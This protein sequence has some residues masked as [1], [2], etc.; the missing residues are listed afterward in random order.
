M[1]TPA[2]PALTN[3]LWKPTFAIKM[4]SINGNGFLLNGYGFSLNGYG[5]SLNG[6]GF[7]LHGSFGQN[8]KSCFQPKNRKMF[9]KTLEFFSKLHVQGSIIGQPKSTNFL[10][11]FGAN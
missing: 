9:L 11:E 5:F 2:G 8:L 1:P 7:P 6:N 4:V 10:E 3:H